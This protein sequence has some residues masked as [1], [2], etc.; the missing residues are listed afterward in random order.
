[1]GPAVISVAMRDNHRPKQD[2]IHEV[3]GLRKQIVDLKEAM[4]ARRRV[5]EALREAESRLRSLTDSAPVGLCLIRRDGTPVTASIPFARMLGYESPADLQHVGGVVGIFA[6]PE[7]RT[8]VLGSAP[9]S[10]GARAFFRHK[11]G[12]R[13]CLGA[14][15]APCE[16]HDAVSVVIYRHAEL[17]P[18]ER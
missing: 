11:N 15:A 4:V 2:L 8:R 6:S 9:I 5:E 1:M 13:L 12:D 3:T 17:P 10:S 7:E 14:L 16:E 18:V